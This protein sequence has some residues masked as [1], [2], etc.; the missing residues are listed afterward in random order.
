MEKLF[1]C[2]CGA[3]ISFKFNFNHSSAYKCFWLRI[4][5]RKCGSNFFSFWNLYQTYS[6]LDRPANAENSLKNAYNLLMTRADKIESKEQREKYLNE[7]T[8]NRNIIGEW[9]NE[10]GNQKY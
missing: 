2:L 10:V 7:V 4:F 5:C 1:D 8:E 6:K 9:Q 3:S